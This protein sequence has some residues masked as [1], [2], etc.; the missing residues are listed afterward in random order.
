MLSR[1]F[2]LA[3]ASVTLLVGVLGPMPGCDE[4][5]NTQKAALVEQETVEKVNELT[6]KA[7]ATDL[8][9]ADKAQVD[10]L[11]AELQAQVVEMK[12]ARKAAEAKDPQVSETS[13]IIGT[14][15]SFAPTPWNA[16][17]ASVISGIAA[18][19]IREPEAKRLKAARE[20]A[21]KI[22]AQIVS[23]IDKAK[24]NSPEFKQAFAAQKM[25]IR[26]GMDDET[27]AEVAKLAV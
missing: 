12:N 27:A 18:F 23:A 20:K 19:L 11:L 15:S 1:R 25:T 16:L 21:E 14:V 7:A 13:A 22:A 9:T 17:I 5:W 10:E 24:M 26:S 3:A 4:A 2:L 8:P 6:S